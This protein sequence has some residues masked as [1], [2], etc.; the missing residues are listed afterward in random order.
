MSE[1]TECPENGCGRRTD[2]SGR[3]GG[4]TA[5]AVP[6]WC[7]YCGGAIAT[8]EWHPVATRRDDTGRVEIHDFCGVECRERWLREQ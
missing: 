4:A 1:S 6:T 7:D 8:D 5:D 3:S 2:G